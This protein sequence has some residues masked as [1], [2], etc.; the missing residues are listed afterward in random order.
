MG[1][2][3]NFSRTPSFDAKS[4]AWCKSLS[5]DAKAGCSA[6]LFQYSGVQAKR[7]SGS[8]NQQTYYSEE[9]STYALKAMPSPLRGTALSDAVL[10]AM[11]S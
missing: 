11:F 6:S 4:A 7:L 8:N 9:A 10:E 3:R 1:I 2:I 5:T